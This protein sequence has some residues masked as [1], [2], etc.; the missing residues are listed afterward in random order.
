[1]VRPGGYPLNRV[2]SQHFERW[3]RLP[4]MSPDGM[5][6]QVHAI[7]LRQTLAPNLNPITLSSPTFSLQEIQVTGEVKYHHLSESQ[8]NLEC[9]GIVQGNWPAF[10]SQCHREN[11]VGDCSRIKENKIHNNQ[12]QR[13]KLDGI[14][15]CKLCFK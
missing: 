3:G 15:V 8:S 10:L 4:L 13:V 2:I 9:G 7:I 11:K 6:L 1:M 5:Q 12:M 14:L